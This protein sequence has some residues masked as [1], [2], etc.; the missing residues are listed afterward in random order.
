VYSN[1]ARRSFPNQKLLEKPEAT[2]WESPQ[3]LLQFNSVS[4][5]S[6]FDAKKPYLDFL[7]LESLLLNPKI[8]R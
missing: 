3:S 2:D 5:I 7:R 1:K 4:K 8:H 6:F